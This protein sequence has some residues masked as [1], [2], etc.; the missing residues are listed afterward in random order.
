MNILDRC[1]LMKSLSPSEKMLC[2]FIVENSKMFVT[3]DKQQLI[4]ELYISSS[5]IYR[6]SK[7][8]QTKGIDDLR[9]QVAIQLIEKEESNK[10]KVDFN[11]PFNEK[12]SLKTICK[13]LLQ[14][15]DESAYLTYKAIDIDELSNAVYLLRNAENIVLMTSNTNTFIAERFSMQLKEISKNVKISSSPYHWKLETVN[16]KNNDVLI[17]N[18]YA[19]RS[20]KQFIELL[21]NLLKKGVAIILLGSTHNQTFMPYATCKLLMADKEDP[22]KKLHSFSTNIATSYLF[23]ILFA[24]IYQENYH[25]NLKYHQYIYE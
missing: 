24:A 7:R 10:L 3:L 13:N 21:P 1:K 2:D 5:T 22:I 14:I 18:S 17:I 20:S 15:Y 19:G 12:D 11:Y 16:L 8:L 23:D 4:K 25:T 9:L 6:F